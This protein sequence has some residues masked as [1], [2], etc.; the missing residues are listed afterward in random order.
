MIK[1]IKR[2]GVILTAICMLA[3]S[4]GLIKPIKA[5][6]A[7]TEA[8]FYFAAGAQ[9]CVRSETVESI[10]TMQFTLNLDFA[11]QEV[12]DYNVT[13]DFADS[14]LN[15]S[16]TIL[17]EYSSQNP[18][19]QVQA[20]DINAE[21]QLTATLSYNLGGVYQEVT[22]TS[23]ARSLLYIYQKLV[24]GNAFD[25]FSAKQEQSIRKI[26]ASA[27][28]GFGAKTAAA[29]FVEAPKKSDGKNYELNKNDYS[30]TDLNKL[31]FKYQLEK[32]NNYIS[33]VYFYFY[34]GNSKYLTFEIN[35]QKGNVWTYA[36]VSYDSLSDPTAEYDAEKDFSGYIVEYYFYGGAYYLKFNIPEGEIYSDENCN[37]GTTDFQSFNASTKG[38]LSTAAYLDDT[39]YTSG[40]LDRI[41]ELQASV[42]EKITANAVLEQ[43]IATL[44][45]E[46]AEL[47]GELAAEQSNVA[48]LTARISELEGLLSEANIEI[49]QL[50]Q[51]YNTL[52][53]AYA[54]LQKENN[55]NIGR[56]DELNASYSTLK[57]EYEAVK[58]AMSGDV[59]SLTDLLNSYR[60]KNAA[61][62]K[63]LSTLKEENAKLKEELE[64]MKSENSNAGMS[65]SSG[66][67]DGGAAVCL[68]LLPAVFVIRR[69]KRYGKK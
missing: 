53:A 57:A 19:I 69:K 22:A 15:D 10:N 13:V 11:G 30:L 3:V 12:T 9:L 28:M 24:E 6:A 55:A 26:V 51:D 4:A 40:L 34:D 16:C 52:S 60:Q 41:E 2:C 54:E 68:L 18:A 7:L 46:K 38:Q 59:K 62:E 49:A 43:R 66:I 29:T 25:E 5:Y 23:N 65:C 58:K 14:T 33:D 61:Y 20:D 42:N 63:E 32:N 21:V 48:A 35:F 1:T 31:I 39:E 50:E 56:Y 37:F 27:T 44:L 17:T 45:G 47:E 67:I 36:Y 64:Q 8:N